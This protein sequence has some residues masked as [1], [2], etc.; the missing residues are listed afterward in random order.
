VNAQLSHTRN[1]THAVA[2]ISIMKVVAAVLLLGLVI[3]SVV[4]EPEEPSNEAETERKVGG[5]CGF[6]LAPCCFLVPQFLGVHTM[7][8]FVGVAFLLLLA[9]GLLTTQRS[10]AKHSTSIRLT[11]RFV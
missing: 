7:T 6:L 3:A 1:L 9:N 4:C 8:C 11:W 2:I 10:L 5:T